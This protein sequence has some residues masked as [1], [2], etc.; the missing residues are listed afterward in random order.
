MAQIYRAP[1]SVPANIAVPKIFLAGSIDL[2]KAVEWQPE[3]EK[4]LAPFDVAIF[5][6]RRLDFD[7]NAVYS[8]DSPYMV[9]QIEWELKRIKQSD[10]VLF[11]FDPKGLAPIT[12]YEHGLVSESVENGFV[13]GIV[14]CPEGYWKR[15][16]VI[17]NSRFHK[18]K[19]VDSFK[20][21]QIETEAAI[22]IHY[23]RPK[24]F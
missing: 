15:A 14:Y 24:H 5:N 21:L 12:L 8:E 10:I 17:V 4:S 2:G 1:E 11:Y 22:H 16:N 23:K 9:E 19:I 13:T 3:L 7:A 18:F 20:Q 6:P